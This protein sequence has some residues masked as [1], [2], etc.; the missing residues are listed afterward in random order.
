MKSIFLS[1][2][3]LI[4]FSQKLYGNALT[5]K[6]FKNL[7]NYKYSSLPKLIEVN[8]NKNRKWI[9]NGRKIILDIQRQNPDYT[10]DGLGKI[11]IKF[12]KKF[13]A[14]LKVTFEDGNIC[15]FN[16]SV[17][18]HGDMMDHIKLSDSGKLFQSIGVSLESGNING[19]TKFY[20]FLQHTRSKDEIFFAELLRKLN[21]LAPRSILVET[22][23]SGVNSKMIFQEKIS[24]EFLESMKRRE[25]PIFEG[26]ETFR[27]TLKHKDNF[28]IAKLDLAKQTNTAWSKKSDIHKE[29]SNISRSKINRFYLSN[30]FA[31]IKNTKKINF[32][33]INLDNDYLDGADKEQ[34]KILNKF[35]LM[36][37][38]VNGFHGLINN[39]RKF[40][41]NSILNFFEPIYY[42]SDLKI[43]NMILQN[44]NYNIY[45][46]QDP[47]KISIYVEELINDIK[48]IDLNKFYQDL[49]KLDNRITKL[50]FT[51]TIN[52]IIKNLKSLDD[53]Y[54]ELSKK[55]SLERNKNK[56]FSIELY[57]DYL[58]LLKNKNTKENF[59]VF[60][61]SNTN[62][63]YK[64]FVYENNYKCTNFKISS[65]NEINLLKGPA[66]IDKK[67][68]H[69][70]GSFDGFNEKNYKDFL[71]LETNI[72]ASKINIL[73]SVLYHD[74]DIDLNWNSEK[75]TLGIIQNKSNARAYFVGGNLSNIEINFK[76]AAS[77]EN[78][79][80]QFLPLDKRGLTGCLSFINVDILKVSVK[81]SS[82]NCEDALNFINTNGQID[83]IEISDATSD[84]LDIDFSNLSIDQILIKNA[85]NDC[86]DV[87]SGRYYI[88]TLKVNNCGD[89]GFSIG[90]KSFVRNEYLNVNNSE[91][92]LASKDSSTTNLNFSEIKNVKTCLAAYKKKQEFF[93][94]SISIKNFMCENYHSKTD[95]DQYSSI[96][97]NK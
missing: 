90:E 62:K 59:L 85:G 25:G 58:Q 87:S 36:L 66:L 88:H 22:N 47:K 33:V 89:K 38:S 19:I 92:G 24:K 69:Y 42:D 93:G 76:G 41:W 2:I 63:F 12:K 91:I 73:N 55:I 97:F 80:T 37:T 15:M 50:Q 81:S 5:C 9:V 20:L 84:A 46:Y 13:K 14:T 40:Y 78:N 8:V 83:K 45:N 67:N 16:G 52:K 27:Q 51:E 64:C 79:Y 57:K 96:L 29:I 32:A 60:N 10:P 31:E 77:D 21:F 56:G 70:I 18:Q 35:N 65:E 1:V 7:S 71:Y 34:S 23:I 26:D 3:L 72:T 94:S 17:K 86:I 30:N 6:D 28:I 44:I 95:I 43:D 54:S 49:K 68:Y 48:E 53:N 11:K 61:N 4:A 82:T 74:E 39:N 75:L